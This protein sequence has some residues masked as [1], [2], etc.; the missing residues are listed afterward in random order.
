MAANL[1]SRTFLAAK[2]ESMSSIKVEKMQDLENKE[3]INENKVEEDRGW[4]R[5]RQSK[6]SLDRKI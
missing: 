1:G 3:Q 2:C 5:K 4:K 6:M